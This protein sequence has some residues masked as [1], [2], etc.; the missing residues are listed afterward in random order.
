MHHCSIVRV[1]LVALPLAGTMVCAL[2]ARPAWSD[3][4]TMPTARTFDTP[5]AAVD[6]L[7][8]A[9]RS[10][11]QAALHAILG[12]GSSKLLDS[13][14]RVA[15]AES[16]KR[17]LAA[18]EVRN[19]LVARGTDRVVLQVGA[20]D[21]PWPFPL[22]KVAGRWTFDSRRGAQQIVDRRIGRN[23]IAA[24]RTALAVVDAEKLYFQLAAKSGTGEYAQRLASA[25][26]RHDGLYWPQAEG[27]PESPLAPLVEQAQD[28][29]YPGELVAGKPSPYQ[30]YFFRILA[31]QGP[32][33][34][35]GAMDY[36]VNGRMTKGFGLIAWP[37]RYGASGIMTFV[38]NQDGIV[39][40]KDL[41]PR[42]DTIAPAMKLLDPDLS[43]ARIDVVNQ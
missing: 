19:A 29:G 25:P 21:W 35:G 39:F 7:V 8:A 10:N 24:I 37:A 1:L 11:D 30:G 16:R 42:T 14:D 40:Q 13:G 28:E 27:E 18:Y 6:A 2:P 9:L 32:N 38:V 26:G 41:G 4:R 5:A 34:P 36:R 31:G 33:A 20:D 17:F 43:W 15:D 12:P 3:D 22:E 23:E